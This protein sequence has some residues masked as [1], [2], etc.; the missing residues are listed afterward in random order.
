MPLRFACGSLLCSFLAGALFTDFFAVFLTLFFAGA[1]LADFFP[2]FFAFFIA[3]GLLLLGL[4]HS[5][6][7]LTPNL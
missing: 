6:R 1:F 4:R 2:A 5:D 3:I 7:V